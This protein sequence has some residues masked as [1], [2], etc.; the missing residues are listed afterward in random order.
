M[1]YRPT[2][3]GAKIVALDPAVQ[4]AAGLGQIDVFEDLSEGDLS[5]CSKIS[6]G[7]DCRGFTFGGI[8]GRC[9]CLNLA[10]TDTMLELKQ[11][12]SDVTGEPTTKSSV[13][14]PEDERILLGWA[15]ETAGVHPPSIQR[16]W[17]GGLVGVDDLLQ[18]TSGGIAYPTGAGVLALLDV[19]ACIVETQEGLAVAAPCRR[20]PRLSDAVTKVLSMPGG[21][22][23]SAQI[24]VFPYIYGVPST[25]PPPIQPGGETPTGVEL[26]VELAGGR[27]S[28]VWWSLLGAGAVLAAYA[29]SRQR[30][31]YA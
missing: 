12:L 17:L 8:L 26:D 18:R 11:L 6:T 4:A 2:A 1:S 15:E 31:L 7:R 13:W 9:V 16:P 29:V 19:A 30:R 5:R 23:P 28:P 3:L 20:Y 27:W 14:T 21:I 10:E 25:T 24:G 22:D